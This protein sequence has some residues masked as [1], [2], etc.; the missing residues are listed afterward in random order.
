[1]TDSGGMQRKTCTNYVYAFICIVVLWTCLFQDIFTYAWG[2]GILHFLTKCVFPWLSLWHHCQ[3][4]THCEICNR[5]TDKSSLAWMN[6][7]MNW[8]YSPTTY[9]IVTTVR[10]KILQC[11][12]NEFFS[13]ITHVLQQPLVVILCFKCFTC[14]L[15]HL[16]WGKWQICEKAETKFWSLRQFCQDFVVM[17]LWNMLIYVFL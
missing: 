1:M 13:H 5:N 7:W 4:Q 10:L 15:Q 6:E 2:L 3:I 11:W 12:L 17:F 9:A 16:K 8:D 14:C